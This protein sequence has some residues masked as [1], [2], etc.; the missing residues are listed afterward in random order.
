MRHFSSQPL[1]VVLL[2]LAS[3][4]FSQAQAQARDGYW[5]NDLSLS[6][7]V[8]LVEGYAASMVRAA[9]ISWGSVVLRE[10][11]ADTAILAGLAF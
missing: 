3:C 2:L 9:D 4:A 1:S 6:L 5:W 11:L 8:G 10:N 7:K